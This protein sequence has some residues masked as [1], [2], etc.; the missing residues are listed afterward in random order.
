MIYIG[1][2]ITDIPCMKLVKEHG[3][4]SIAV[5]QKETKSSV[6]EL[7]R[8]GRVDFIALAD[9]TEGGEL[10][11]IVKSVIEKESGF[12]TAENTTV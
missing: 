1:D 11:T 5:Y 7:L 2:G 3:G 9:Y 4:N 8:T 12:V 6:S 10:D